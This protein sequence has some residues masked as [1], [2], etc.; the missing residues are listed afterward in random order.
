M[1]VQHSI[2]AICLAAFAGS[3]S[4]LAKGNDGNPT[5]V[6]VINFP[7]TPTY[8]FVG[9][10]DADHTVSSSQL[11]TVGQFYCKEHFGDGARIATSREMRKA[12]AT[13]EADTEAEW[14]TVLPPIL[15]SL[16]LPGGSIPYGYGW[17]TEDE[18]T[19]N[20]YLVDNYGQVEKNG[21]PAEGTGDSATVACSIPDA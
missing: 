13:V 11:F 1:K 21:S 20:I 3:G 18:S 8:S 15:G 12:F 6:E 4:A 16:T 2:I 19:S 5:Q 9:Y 10:T 14:Q 17:F 7:T